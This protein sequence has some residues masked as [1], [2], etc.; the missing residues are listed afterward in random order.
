SGSL[1]KLVCQVSTHFQH[2]GNGQD[3]DEAIVLH[4]EVL[5]LW[6]VGHTQQSL[7]LNNLADRLSTHF[8]HRGND[9]DLDEAIVFHR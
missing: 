9:Q 4:R 2:R 1:N 3:L 6:P 7:S 5:N 8:D